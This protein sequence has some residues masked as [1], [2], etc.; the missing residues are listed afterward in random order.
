MYTQGFYLWWIKEKKLQRNR[1]KRPLD[2]NFTNAEKFV[3]RTS[4]PKLCS[5]I[6]NIPCWSLPGMMLQILAICTDQVPSCMDGNKISKCCCP[7]RW[8]HGRRVVDNIF[9]LL[10]SWKPYDYNFLVRN[11]YNVLCAEA[12]RNLM[13]QEIN[14]VMQSVS[15]CVSVYYVKEW[16]IMSMRVTELKNG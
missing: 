4:A 13:T 6:V 11:Y 14:G 7:E 1:E 16:A 8:T 5:V 10:P 2:C 15:V 9:C 3:W 12:T